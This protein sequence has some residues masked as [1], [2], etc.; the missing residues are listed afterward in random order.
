VGR[1][2]SGISVPYAHGFVWIPLG[3]QLAKKKIS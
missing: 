1:R 2:R 3:F